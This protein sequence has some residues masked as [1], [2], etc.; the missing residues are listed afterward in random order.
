V[1]GRVLVRSAQGASNLT[2]RSKSKPGS[3]EM[4]AQ[5]EADCRIVGRAESLI[6]WRRPMSGP[7]DWNKPVSNLPGVLED[8]MSGRKDRKRPTSR[9]N[10]FSARRRGI[11]KDR[12]A[13][14]LHKSPRHRRPDSRSRSF[15][16][17]TTRKRFNFRIGIEVLRYSKRTAKLLGD[18]RA[19]DE[20]SHLN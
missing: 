12:A 15:D 8:G 6:T 13:A 19:E 2:G 17:R 18:L 11:P 10:P 20:I 7:H 5:R 4:S 16:E 3:P 14:R 1:A 9:R